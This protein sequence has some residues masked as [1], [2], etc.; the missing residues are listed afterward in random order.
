MSAV[1]LGVTDGPTMSAVIE[2]QSKY[3]RIQAGEDVNESGVL[4]ESRFLID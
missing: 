4:I 1:L 3:H 2:S